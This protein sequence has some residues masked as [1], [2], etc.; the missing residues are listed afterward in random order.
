[1]QTRNCWE[2]LCYLR[3][4]RGVR[5]V[6]VDAICINQ[7]DDQEKKHQVDRMRDIYSNC[8]RVVLWLGSDLL[9]KPND[10]HHP[11]RKP[12]H[13]LVLQ[14]TSQISPGKVDDPHPK[15]QSYLL[16]R[17]YFTRVWIIQELILAPMVVVQVHNTLYWANGTTSRI[18]QK[19]AL[20]GGE[21]LIAPWERASAPWLQFVAG[22]RDVLRGYTFTE[23]LSLTSRSRA[24]DNR[25]RIFGVLGLLPNTHALR[26]EYNLSSQHVFTGL[27]AYLIL[28][29]REVHLL[30]Q[31]AGILAS[32]RHRLT[33][34]P[35]WENPD[36][37]ERIF[38]NPA[39][40]LAR[41][42]DWLKFQ[43]V[44]MRQFASLPS[45]HAL[46]NVMLHRFTDPLARERASERP[47]M[48]DRKFSTYTI[49]Y[50]W[51]Y[52]AGKSTVHRAVPIQ[53]TMLTTYPWFADTC[54]HG[55]TGTLSLHITRLT[56]FT[57]LPLKIC[58]YANMDI[59]WARTA[60]DMSHVFLGIHH[61]LCNDASTT[62]AGASSSGLS[63]GDEVFVLQPDQYSPHIYLVLRPIPATF[64][65][66]SD[67]VSNP[68]FQLVTYCPLVYFGTTAGDP[69]KPINTSCHL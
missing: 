48:V 21:Y 54:V 23:A 36:S 38:V 17:R 37:W 14:Q 8:T 52:C 25:D 19:R 47:T 40:P 60:H 31:A 24:S 69:D 58:E 13:N 1:M 50:F 3:P 26:P 18:L 42:D 45:E 4:R 27:F 55:D 20:P 32:R 22:G 11:Q 12:F 63:L 30:C 49:M 64:R 28:E 16:A 10:C 9:A 53:P 39:N 67:G 43:K 68:S 44:L 5:L 57:S 65:T 6:W 41:Q 7:A 61:G 15:P 35:A 34:V 29:R 46:E 56:S 66:S 59:L 33:W 62:E 2:M 51:A